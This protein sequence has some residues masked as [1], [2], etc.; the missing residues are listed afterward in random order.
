MELLK[1]SRPIGTYSHNDKNIFSLYTNKFIIII[2]SYQCF[3]LIEYIL[4]KV[5]KTKLNN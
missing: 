3:N 2:L 4:N 5:C 1:K